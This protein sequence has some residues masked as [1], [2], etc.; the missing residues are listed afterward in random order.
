MRCP[1]F[2]LS[3]IFQKHIRIGK[4]DP[5]IFWAFRKTGI[6]KVNCKRRSDFYN[7]PFTN[8]FSKVVSVPGLRQVLT[9]P[10]FNRNWKNGSETGSWGLSPRAAEEGFKNNKRLWHVILVILL[11]IQVNNINN[12]FSIIYKYLIYVEWGRNSALGRILFH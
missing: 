7:S 8:G 4:I 10:G 9:K 5:S 6:D 11:V 3:I 12:L 2:L 1:G